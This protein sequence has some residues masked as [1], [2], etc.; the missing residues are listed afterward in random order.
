MTVTPDGTLAAGRAIAVADGA[1]DGRGGPPVQDVRQSG[2]R[3]RVTVSK[4]NIIGCL[5]FPTVS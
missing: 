3:T 2:D 5:Y 4:R 1:R